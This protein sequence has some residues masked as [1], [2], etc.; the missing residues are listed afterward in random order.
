MRYKI[1]QCIRQ[2]QIGGGES[3]LLSLVANMDREQFDPVV[4]SFTD[5]PMITELEKLGVKTHIIPTTR[6]FDLSIWGKVKKLVRTEAPVLVHAHGTRA[7]S[8]VFRACRSGKIPWVYTIHGWSFHIDQ[9]P[10]V[11]TARIAGERLLTASSTVNISVSA[12][13]KESGAKYIPGLRSEVV[14]NGI[15][16]L[17]FD[18]SR[19]DRKLRDTLGYSKDDIIVLFVARFT[20]QKQPLTLIKAFE[21]VVSANPRVKLLMVGEGEQLEEGKR[22]ASASGAKDAIR[23]LPFRKDVPD[24]LAMA[25]I[26]VLPSLWEGLPI[27]LLE[28]MSMAKAVIASKVDGTTEIISDTINGLL[29]N[30]GS[31]EKELAEKILKLSRDKELMER[32][33]MAARKTVQQR[34]NALEMTREIETIYLKLIRNGI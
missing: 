10:W 16:Q 1:L 7:A 3:H 31:L 24:L 28:A 14:N 34:F 13:N 19:Y 25:D 9:K 4:L 22:S 20:L 33:G 12:S 2:G 6:P 5:G 21:S 27:G 11:R 30:T 29:V 18:P 23:F 15:D 26:Y 32:L 17:K 8:N